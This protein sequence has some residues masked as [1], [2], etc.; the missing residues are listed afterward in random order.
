M[1]YIVNDKC[2]VNVAPSIYVEV[3]I[4]KDGNI[5]PTDNKIEV[6]G[7]TLVRQTTLQDCLNKFVKNEPEHI[8]YVMDMKYNKRKR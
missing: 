5:T 7:D 3:V 6:N 4:S 8:G 1:L 2:C